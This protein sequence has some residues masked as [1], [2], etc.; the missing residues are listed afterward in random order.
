MKA[1]QPP[2]KTVDEYIAGFPGA[3]QAVLERVR[4]A[5]RKAVPGAEEAISYRIP[6]YKLN[7][8]YVIYFAG[9]KEHYSLYPVTERTQAVFRDALAP[10][11]VSKGTIRFP[12]SARIPTELIG[13][14]AEFRAKEVAGHSKA[15]GTRQKAT[16]TK[17]AARK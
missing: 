14:I 4:N 12:L 13:R 15:K 8:R 1:V 5:I 9:W 6:T 10:Y 3:V 7:G 11:K 2:P 17:A 16:V